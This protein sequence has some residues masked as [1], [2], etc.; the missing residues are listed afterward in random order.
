MEENG[1]GARVKD[2]SE[3]PANSFLPAAVRDSREWPEDGRMEGNTQ[4][5]RVWIEVNGL[6][7]PFYLLPYLA[8]GV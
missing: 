5:A 6:R 1:H 4:G 2:R 3:W 8:L 7:I